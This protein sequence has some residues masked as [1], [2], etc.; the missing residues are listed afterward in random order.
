MILCEQGVFGLQQGISGSQQRVVD[1][2]KRVG[3]GSF[4]FVFLFL[5]LLR[6]LLGKPYLNLVLV[7][8]FP[9]HL[10]L[11]SILVLGR[12]EESLRLLAMLYFYRGVR[13]ER[14]LLLEGVLVLWQLILFLLLGLV[15]GC[16]FVIPSFFPSF[17]VLFLL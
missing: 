6:F 16:L 10:D 9:L 5:L 17:S 12:N 2:L 8:G 15:G 4:A 11:F 1:S 7:N 14:Y 3:K 13:V